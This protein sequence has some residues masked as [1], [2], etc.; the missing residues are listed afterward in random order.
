MRY[1]R[2]FSI[3][4]CNERV[5]TFYDLIYSKDIKMTSASLTLAFSITDVWSVS[6]RAR[7]SDY[8]I[9]FPKMYV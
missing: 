9:A 7:E 4:D 5:V 6:R 8:E 1:W 2:V 3:N